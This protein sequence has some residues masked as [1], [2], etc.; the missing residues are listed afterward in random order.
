[1]L[2]CKTVTLFFLCIL[3]EFCLITVV[4]ELMQLFSV[5]T[6]GNDMLHGPNKGCIAS[7]LI[8]DFDIVNNNQLSNYIL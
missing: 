3:N 2:D 4:S 5:W 7:F 6:K 8:Q 1:M